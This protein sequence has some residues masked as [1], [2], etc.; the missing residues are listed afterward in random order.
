[1]ALDRHLRGIDHLLVAVADL[2]GAAADYRRLGF[3]VTPRGRHRGWPTGNHCVMFEEGYLE[4]LGRVEA[5]AGRHRL[6]ESLARGEGGLGIALASDD[7]EATAA[8]WRAA[9]LEV[10]GPLDLAR[11]LEDEERGELTLRFRN[12]LPDP[13]LLGDLVLFACHHLTPEQLRRPEWLRHENG[14]RGIRS[15][16]VL[17]ARPEPVVTALTRLLGEAARSET[18]QVTTFHTGG[19]PILV[20]P[21]EDVLLLHP[22]V[23]EAPAV[24]EPRLV[25]VSLEVADPGRTAA[26]LR[27]RELPVRRIA[28]G[29]ALPPAAG[30]GLVLEFVA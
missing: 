26:L 28:D 3:A 14:V 5:G 6:D 21:P 13:R 1:M 30:R 29:F 15:C 24:G 2:G 4:L 10:E 20:A 11:L 27:A 7:P 12:V 22:T 8:A 17:A 16:T 19:A 25:A 18:D 23:G 9:G